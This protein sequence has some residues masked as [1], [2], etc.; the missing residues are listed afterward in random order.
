MTKRASSLHIE[1]SRVKLINSLVIKR[2][3]QLALERRNHSLG[4]ISGQ[5]LLLEKGISHPSPVS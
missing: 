3:I 1:V 4:L 2:L 5:I